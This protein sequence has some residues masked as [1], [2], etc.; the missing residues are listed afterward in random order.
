I[1]DIGHA[2]T[3]L[4]MPGAITRMLL[5]EDTVDR[6]GALP[7]PLASLLRLETASEDGDLQRLTE[8]FHLNLSA[9]GMLAFIV[10]LFIV[11][12]TIGLAF[13]QRRGLL[14][15]LR[16]CGVSLR[17]LV[18]ALAVE[19]GTFAVL[20]GMAGVFTGYGLAAFLLPDVAASL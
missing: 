19:L 17:V 4:R 6:I 11:H 14:R 20:G 12:A 5:A 18:S 1:V 15:T 13:E 10:G 7:A 16:S 9:L 3:L 8:S 2:Q